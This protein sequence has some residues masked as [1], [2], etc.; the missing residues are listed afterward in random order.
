MAAHDF[1]IALIGELA[2]HDFS[3]GSHSKARSVQVSVVRVQ[4]ETP[5][6][7]CKAFQLHLY[8][9]IKLLTGLAQSPLS[10]RG[11]R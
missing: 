3:V 2:L 6:Q 5:L 7:I 1:D 10:A 9:L 4:G 11:C 8:H